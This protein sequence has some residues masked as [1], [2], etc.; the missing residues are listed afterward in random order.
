MT[1]CGLPGASDRCYPSGGRSP[2][3]RARDPALGGS[4]DHEQ[5]CLLHQAADALL[6]VPVFLAARAGAILRRSTLTR[7]GLA[8]ALPPVLGV[9]VLGAGQPATTVATHARPITALPQA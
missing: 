7:A 1:F 3:E 9:G 8:L 5:E 4:P 6:A 2:P